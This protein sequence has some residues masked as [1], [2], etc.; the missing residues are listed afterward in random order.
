[1]PC[2]RHAGPHRAGHEDA[3]AVLRPGLGTA[4]SLPGAAA[5]AVGSRLCPLLTACSASP[6]REAAAAVHS[7]FS[8]VQ[9]GSS[10]SVQFGS[11]TSSRPVQF[12]S[13]RFSWFSGWWRP[14]PA[15]A[16]DGREWADELGQ[17][18]PQPQTQP[19]PCWGTPRP[20]DSVHDV[21]HR[22]AKEVRIRPESSQGRAR[23]GP[24]DE[25]P[26]WNTGG[27]S[28]TPSRRRGLSTV[29]GA[30]QDLTSGHS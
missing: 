22:P 8:S 21:T 27:R 16:G 7:Q 28:A 14:A 5:A 25:P 23:A 6:A 4:R 24:G 15:L 29:A 17:P 1:V 13:V 2:V 18:Q 10:R 3:H 30:V 20:S 11:S 12:S 9:F 26:R 19:Q